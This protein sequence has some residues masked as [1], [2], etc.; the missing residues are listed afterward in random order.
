MKLAMPLLFAT[1]LLT[2]GAQN[3]VPGIA[4]SAY[5]LKNKFDYI[6]AEPFKG[7]KKLSRVHVKY[8]FKLPTS[9]TLTIQ[10][11]SKAYP[12]GKQ[13]FTKTSKIQ[14]VAIDYDYDQ[15]GGLKNYPSIVLRFNM[16]SSYGNDQVDISLKINQYQDINLTSGGTY[17]SDKT[18]A[19]YRYNQGVEYYS[20]KFT[21]SNISNDLTITSLGGI[22][23]SDFMFDYDVFDGY[24]LKVRSSHIMLMC[25]ADDYPNF[26]EYLVDG[27]ARKLYITPF[28]SAVRKGYYF[29]NNDQYYVNPI[30]LDMSTTEQD[31]YV[32]TDYIYFP[33]VN[34]EKV[35]TLILVAEDVGI[36]GSRLVYTRNVRVDNKLYGNCADS[37]FCLSTEEAVPDID[38]GTVI[39]H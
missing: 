33:F 20:E 7:G 32:M 3:V 17:E 2:T 16:T 29:T 28:Y 35:Y 10:V 11:I 26:G 19:V 15:T 4:T 34:P 1:S 39:K 22:K 37:L 8:S 21:F 31:G 36:N 23:I 13:L 18:L 14:K 27:L 6:S 5:N 9:S 24:Q 12:N 38:N 30:S 25:D